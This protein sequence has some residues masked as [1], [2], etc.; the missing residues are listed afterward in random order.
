LADT[1]NEPGV[2]SGLDYA[3]EVTAMVTSAD[4]IRRI[5][6]ARDLSDIV[7]ANKL[8][9]IDVVGSDEAARGRLLQELGLDPAE[10]SWMQRFGQVGRMA[11][12]HRKLRV[13]TWIAERPEALTELHLLCLQKMILTVW[14]GNADALNGIRGQFTERASELE[15]S[16]Y[17]A[18]GILLQFL[19]DTLHQAISEVDDKL[20]SLRRQGELRPGSLDLATLMDQLHRLQSIWSNVVRYRSSVR[21]AITG[22]EALPEIDQRGVTELKE[23]AHQVEDVELRM[24]HR[25]LWASHIMQLYATALAQRQ[26]EQINR[27]T[28]V[29]TIFLPITFLTGFFGMNFNWMNQGLGSAIAFL[30]LGILLPLSSVLLTALWFR[31]RGLI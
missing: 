26:G 2:H 16:P 14:N 4:G 25:S 30:L 21:L 24:E 18:A 10:Q 29:A 31:Q 1:P 8:C 13:V 17:Q 15:R 19:L 9:W 3:S 28:L 11:I 27:L 23:Y 5:G 6:T 20:E 22:V 12:D 7:S